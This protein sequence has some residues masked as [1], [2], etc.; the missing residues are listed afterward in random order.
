MAYDERL[1][2]RIRDK[3]QGVAAVEEKHMFGGLSF[4][5]RGHMTV[6]IV[7][8]EMIA[9]VGADGEET[10]LK[11]KGA[12]PMDFTG[13]PM[14]GWITVSPEGFAGAGLGR[15]VDTCLAFNGTLPE[16]AA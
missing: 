7:G 16:K 8:D 12:R 15:W 10:A 5:V 3:L 9:R 1:A 14:S 13:R 11:R 2:G 6:G 4:M